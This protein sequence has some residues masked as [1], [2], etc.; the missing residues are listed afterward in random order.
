MG[1]EYP[2]PARKQSVRVKLNWKTTPAQ[3]LKSYFL[4]CDWCCHDFHYFEKCREPACGCW[5]DEEAATLGRVIAYRYFRECYRGSPIL[6][7]NLINERLETLLLEMEEMNSQ[8]QILYERLRE[9]E[10]PQN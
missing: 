5:E 8:L 9:F 2:I 10:N 4:A 3:E 1:F 6:L 7:A